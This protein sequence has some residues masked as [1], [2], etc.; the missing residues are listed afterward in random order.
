MP[1]LELIAPKARTT[2]R[3]FGGSRRPESAVPN[4]LL[5]QAA[6][7]LEIISL[8]ATA[9]WTVS[10]IAWHLQLGSES[11][12]LGFAPYQLSDNVAV[13]AVIASL[14][15]F[16][17]ARNTHRE[18]RFIPNLGLGYMVLTST[19][20]GLIT[21]WYIDPSIGQPVIAPTISWIGVVILMFAAVIPISTP[22]TIIAGLIAASMNPIGMLIARERGVWHFDSSLNALMMHYP[23]YVLIGVAVVIARVVTMLGQEVSKAREMGSYQLGDLLKRGGMGEVYRATHTMLARPAA[24]KLIRP[25]MLGGGNGDDAQI[26]VKRFHR[27]AAA[28]ASLRSPHTVELFDFGVTE[29]QTLYF[30]MKLLQ[31]MDL[32]SMVQKH[33]PLP[34]AR[35]I[36][37]LCQA[38]ESLEEAHA[39][40]LVHRDIKPANIHVGHVGIR[41]DF[42]KVLNFGLVKSVAASSEVSLKVLDFGLAKSLAESGEV[43]PDTAVG[44]TNGTPAYMAPAMALGETV[45]G[46]ADIY[47]LGCVAYYLL[48]GKLVF[49]AE[50][51][52]EM[53]ARHLHNE[54]VAPSIRVG[55]DIPQRLELLVLSCLAKNADA[56]PT[57]AG[58]L[59]QALRALD[60]QLWSDAQAKEWWAGNRTE[61]LC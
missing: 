10:S 15:L 39:R 50:S 58:S 18:P 11:G 34:A 24:I 6:R 59:R 46:R 25:E 35:V 27:E 9:L 22:K 56:R 51:P 42:V 30:V 31:G 1:Q 28:A 45:D 41:D 48:T 49:E 29:D 8:L 20:I 55:I 36:H 52:L 16:Y 3:S 38:C 19:A 13:V 54:P 14:A 4:D 57:T 5:K 21:H 7:R 26:A 43:Y 40:G 12:Q 53:V 60:V 33:G 2:P 32:E 61:V 47:A 23:D 37:I 17:Y 44:P